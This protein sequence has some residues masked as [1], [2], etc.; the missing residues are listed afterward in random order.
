MKKT[1]FIIVTLVVLGCLAQTQTVTQIGFIIKNAIPDVE[2]IAVI[3]PEHMKSKYTAEARTAQLVTRKNVTIY[4]VSRMSELSDA[5]FNIRRMKNVVAVVMTDESIL[6]AKDVKFVIDKF[7]SS[8]I[9]V[10]SNR[11][12]DTLLGALFSIIVRDNLVEKHINR[13]VASALNLNLSEEF[14]AECVI[15][16]E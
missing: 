13:I 2:N 9:P 16:V 10:V 5:V 8:N 4:G 6:T 12:K 14:I 11:D 3:Y 1:A 15:D 7:T